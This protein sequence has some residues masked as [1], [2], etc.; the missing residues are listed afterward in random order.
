MGAPPTDDF[1]LY[2]DG[3]RLVEHAV[4]RRLR[5]HQPAPDDHCGRGSSRTPTREPA[6]CTAAR[7]S[8]TPRPASSPAMCMRLTN[9]GSQYL[10]ANLDSDNEPLDEHG[11]VPAHPAD[12][13]PRGAGLVPERVRQ[14]DAFPAADRPALPPCRQP[15]L[16]VPSS[17]GGSRRLYG[18]PLLAPR[19]R[20]DVAPGELDPDRPCKKVG[21]PSFAST[22]PSSPSSTSSWRPGEIDRVG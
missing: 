21:S 4:G 3:L 6:S 7:R 14:P 2:E 15:E 16:P 5:V 1:R 22:A 12:G 17:R 18:R 13:H 9:I 11:D 19:N 8:S 10:V 20:K